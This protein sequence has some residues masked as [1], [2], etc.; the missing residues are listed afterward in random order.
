MPH[1]VRVLPVDFGNLTERQLHIR[2][3]MGPFGEDD[4]GPVERTFLNYPEFVR[5][6]GRL[7]TRVTITTDLGLRLAELAI[8]RTV[9]LMDCETLWTL[10]T[11]RARSIG[12]SDDALRAVASGNADGALTGMAAQIVEA[13]DE[14][15]FTHYLSDEKWFR[16]DRLGANG[17]LDLISTYG[18]YVTLAVAVSSMGISPGD[19][20][21]GYGP[22]L[23]RLRSLPIAAPQGLV[24]PKDPAKRVFEAFYD[25]LT[26]AQIEQTRRMGRRGKP[27][28]SKL[29]KAMINYVEFLKAIS[30]FGIRAI[31]KSSLPTRLWQL[32]CMRTVWI[33][34][35]E[36]LWSQ[37]R[38]ACLQ[39]GITDEV[40]NG[41]AEGPDSAALGGYDQ[42][43]VA[44]V[45][46]M[47]TS[48]RLSDE[49][50]SRFDEFGP[51][52]ATDLMLVHG[53]YV[54]QACLARSF[55]TTLEEGS[56]GYADAIQP[57]RINQHR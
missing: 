8:L 5:S 53:L 26:P 38:K 3:K 4:A 2:S 24:A 50:W 21:A 56:S 52:A 27:G 46:E 23:V 31:D 48:G 45:D 14:L 22:A 17:P 32:A 20:E 18:L 42:A 57:L 10:H 49:L 35:S 29:Q 43:I 51:E 12:I 9:W 16:L 44:A 13:I 25:E 11:K 34:D 47:H 30:P 41:V 54:L 19:G 15:H 55:G 40:L 28:T 37:H 6:I 1:P 33:C 36:Y 39:I 7:S